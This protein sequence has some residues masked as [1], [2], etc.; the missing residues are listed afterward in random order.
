MKRFLLVAVIG[1]GLM[2][3]AGIASAYTNIDNFCTGTYQL[4]GSAAAATSQDSAVVAR[5]TAP[6]ISVTKLAKNMRTLQTADYSVNAVIGD[7]VEF[8]IIWSNSGEADADTIILKDY[9]PSN[10]I[11]LSVTSDTAT[12]G[13]AGT[14]AV[15]AASTLTITKTAVQGTDAGPDNGAVKFVGKL[16]N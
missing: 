13:V 12:A 2:G 7:S 9:V 15:F 1:L 6:V 14:G 5:Q 4:T 16:N 3:M 11:T 8:T 10:F